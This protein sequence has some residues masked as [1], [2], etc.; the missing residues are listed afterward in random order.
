MFELV[1]KRLA[2]SSDVIFV[3]GVFIVLLVV[4]IVKLWKKLNDQEKL[5][6]KT[7]KKLNSDILKALV[8]N[9]AAMVSANNNYKELRDDLKD[10]KE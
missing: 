4:V 1:L 7:I 10:S 6:K 5:N 2:D 8:D 9:T 3:M